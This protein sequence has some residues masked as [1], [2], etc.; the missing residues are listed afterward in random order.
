MNVVLIEL[1]EST[2][3][4]LD[5]VSVGTVVVTGI[6]PESVLAE[7]LIEVDVPDVLLTPDVV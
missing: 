5:H 6:V 7:V 3:V 2:Y 1:E 4:T